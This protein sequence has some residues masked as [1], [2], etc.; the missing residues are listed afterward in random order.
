MSCIFFVP[1]KLDAE[2]HENIV[3][4]EDEPHQHEHLDHLD[5]GCRLQTVW[6]AQEPENVSRLIAVRSCSKIVIL[7]LVKGMMDV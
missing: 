4:A 5:R 3:E 7:Y 1:D 6:Y 2:L